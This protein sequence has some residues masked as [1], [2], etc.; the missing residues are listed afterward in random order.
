MPKEIARA[1]IEHLKKLLETETD[2][3]KRV[4]IEG[5]L[6]EEEQKLAKL[7]RRDGRKEG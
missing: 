7:T 2:A 5:R 1:N 3:E 4:V 6:A